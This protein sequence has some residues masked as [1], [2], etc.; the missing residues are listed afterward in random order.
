MNSLTD[1][2]M[3]R[4]LY[5]AGMHGIPIEL[6]V[7][8]VCCLVPGIPGVSDSIQVRSIVGRF[9]EHSRIYAF[10]FGGETTHL[11]GSA[12]WMTRNL[13]RR[14]EVL[15]PIQDPALKQRCEDILDAVFRDNWMARLLN[16]DG[17]YTKLRDTRPP[18]PFLSQQY[19]LRQARLRQRKIDTTLHSPQQPTPI[20][21]A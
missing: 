12:D 10:T 1:P 20:A 3:I 4:T 13:T 21:H 7:R 5:R 14:I 11:T 18:D 8:G 17:S 6:S 2:E 9:L 16:P 15:F 19:F